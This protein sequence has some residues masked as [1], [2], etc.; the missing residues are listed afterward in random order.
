MSSLSHFELSAED[1]QIL[2]EIS[3]LEVDAM[4]PAYHDLHMFQ[5]RS[6]VF[7]V[8]YRLNGDMDQRRMPERIAV[9]QSSP[10]A[11][12]ALEAE[13]TMVDSY[14]DRWIIRW[15]PVGGDEMRNWLFR[16]EAS[17]VRL[18]FHLRILRHQG[19]D[20]D[21]PKHYAHLLQVAEFIF[22]DALAHD[23]VAYFAFKTG[24]ILFAAHIILRLGDRRDLI[25]RMA[26]RMAGDPERPPINTSTK[27]NGYQMLSMLS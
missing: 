11:D 7:C 20:I 15:C 27:Y 25:L 3:P 18:L 19:P 6:Q 21:F 22:E 5:V 12:I 14:I 10:D 4:I 17:G 1:M 16:L 23:H 9:A 24:Y 8:K 13:H 26:L 2:Q